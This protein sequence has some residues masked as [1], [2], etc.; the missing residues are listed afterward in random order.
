MKRHVP[1]LILALLV[2]TLLVPGIAYALSYD[3]NVVDH[4]VCPIRLV[5]I[6]EKLEE[7]ETIAYNN[8][9]THILVIVKELLR[10]INRTNISCIELLLVD[11]IIENLRKLAEYKFLP[12]NISTYHITSELSTK[13]RNLDRL[14]AIEPPYYTPIN[15]GQYTS[16]TMSAITDTVVMEF[17]R[18]TNKGI[19][20]WIDQENARLNKTIYESAISINTCNVLLREDSQINPYIFIVSVISLTM[21]LVVAIKLFRPK[22][23]I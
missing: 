9:N 22:V 12:K 16:T 20:S 17:P 18:K 8:N 19:Y 4:R 13:Q 15:L 3:N 1:T 23:N 6:I 5:E 10:Y 2:A 14:R 7:L 11:N 21:L